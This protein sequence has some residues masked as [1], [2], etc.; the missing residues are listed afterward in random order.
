MVHTLLRSAV[1]PNSHRRL[2][3]CAVEKKKWGREEE[4]E[5]NARQERGDVQQA[6]AG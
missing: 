5:D 1:G 4:S 6:R 3:T 2:D